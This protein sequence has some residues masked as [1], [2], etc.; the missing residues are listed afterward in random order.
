MSH[1]LGDAHK[2]LNLEL[3][4]SDQESEVSRKDSEEGS[5]FDIFENMVGE[6]MSECNDIGRFDVYKELHSIALHWL[7][8]KTLSKIS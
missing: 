2:L 5:T 6:A 4:Q 3:S 8:Y 1:I 7:Q